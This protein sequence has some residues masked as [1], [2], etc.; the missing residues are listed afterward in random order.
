MLKQVRDHIE[1]PKGKQRWGWVDKTLVLA[2]CV[3]FS[4][5]P[6]VMAA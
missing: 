4:P 5:V 3:L 1:Q 6:A 2:I